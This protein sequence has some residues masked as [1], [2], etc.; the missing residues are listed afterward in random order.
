MATK[1][2]AEQ[3]FRV[4]LRQFICLVAADQLLTQALSFNI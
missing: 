2:A 1:A 3:A 4:T